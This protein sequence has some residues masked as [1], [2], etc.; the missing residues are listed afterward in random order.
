MNQIQLILCLIGIIFCGCQSKELTIKDLKFFDLEKQNWEII[1][2]ILNRCIP[3]KTRKSLN[4]K[5][6]ANQTKAKK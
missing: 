5:T 2:V 1:K 3:A 4:V 6:Q